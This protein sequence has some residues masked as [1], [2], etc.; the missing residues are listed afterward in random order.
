M[1]TSFQEFIQKKARE[2]LHDDRRE[3]IAEWIVSIN[4]LTGTM[5]N[6]IRQS[7]PEGLVTV[8]PLALRRIEQGLGEYEVQGMRIQLGTSEIKVV[9]I[10]R[11]ALG[12]VPVLDSL[13]MPVAGRVDITNGIEKM[14]L[15]RTLQGGEKWHVLDEQYEWSEFNQT[16]FEAVLQEMMS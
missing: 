12:A 11:H 16:R 1:S 5:L 7:D 10:G 3:L 4:Q 8:S 2:E 6:W 13:T 14:L 9:P 15:F